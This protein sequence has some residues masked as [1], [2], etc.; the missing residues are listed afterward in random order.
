VKVGDLVSFLR[1]CDYKKLGIVIKDPH[2]AET[3]IHVLFPS[4]FKIIHRSLLE[5]INESR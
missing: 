5:V 4:G 2:P 3:G 1:G